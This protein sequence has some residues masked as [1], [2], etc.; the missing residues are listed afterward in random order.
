MKNF[1]L[2]LWDDL[3]AKRLWPVAAVLLLVAVA[4]PVFVM[5]PA[6]EPA[7]SEVK[8]AAQPAQGTPAVVVDGAR[9]SS[10]L[11]VFGKKDPFRP[12]AAALEPSTSGATAAA[13]SP[14]GASALPAPAMGSGAGGGGSSVQG[15]G[16]GSSPTAP[17]LAPAPPRGAPKRVAYTYVADVTLTRNDRSRRIRRLD[18]LDM[19]PSQESPLLIFLGV[20]S[21][22][23]RAVFLV[24]STL[25][26]KGE[27]RCS[28]RPSQCA[29]LSLGAGAEHGFADADGNT[30]FLRINE[31]R[32]VPVSKAAS[33]SRR[34]A[35][36]GAATGK[37]R[38]FVPP[39]LADLI[40][41]SSPDS[42]R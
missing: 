17:Q 1:A 23:D 14:A 42:R 16:R 9:G 21:D 28:P 7:A 13:G 10:N 34:R 32:K 40:T 36:A 6:Q 11:G 18:R 37:G 15:P 19:L 27:G 24:D 38:R 2:D 33:S 39:V 30:F 31:I 35:R 41:V 8:S 29:T 20:T 26:A 3:R 22:G 5:K 25:E 12:P 4:I